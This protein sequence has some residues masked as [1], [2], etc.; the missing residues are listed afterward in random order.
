ML[1]GISLLMFTLGLLLGKLA[2]L[3]KLLHCVNVWRK[4]VTAKFGGLIN[5]LT[6]LLVQEKVKITINVCYQTSWGAI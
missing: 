2:S 1:Q 6:W 4:D 3:E 5:S